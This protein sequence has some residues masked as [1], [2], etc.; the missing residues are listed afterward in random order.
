MRH[1]THGKKKAIQRDRAAA[2]GM[3]APFLLFFVLF[4]LYPLL[5]NLYYS[6][7]NYNLGNKTK[8]IGPPTTESCLPITGFWNLCEILQSMHCS[9]LSF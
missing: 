6:F 2:Y 7:T 9:A 8:W 4:V 3:L 1:S 5:K